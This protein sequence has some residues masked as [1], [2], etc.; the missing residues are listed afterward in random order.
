MARADAGVV[1]SQGKSAFMGYDPVWRFR[2]SSR[3]ACAFKG[4]LRIEI[5][6]TF[7][8]KALVVLGFRPLPCG[9]RSDRASR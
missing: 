5:L 9:S 7:G 6:V 4:A 1:I 8:R 2:P 3:N